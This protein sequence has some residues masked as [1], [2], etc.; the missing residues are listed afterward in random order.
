MS[1]KSSDTSL[2]GQQLNRSAEIWNL[3]KRLTGVADFE[4]CL[5]GFCL[6]LGDGSR[7]WIG[8]FDRFMER[9]MELATTMQLHPGTPEDASLIILLAKNDGT[10][11]VAY[12]P[13]ETHTWNRIVHKYWH[14]WYRP[15]LPD[16]LWQSILSDEK[17]AII[18]PFLLFASAFIYRGSI[19]RGGLPFHA[20]LVE[21][22]GQGVILAAPGGTGKTTCYQR[23]L[24]PWQAHCDDEVL[25]ALAPDGRYLAHPFPTWSNFFFQRQEKSWKVEAA[26]PLAGIFFLEQSPNDYS[27]PSGHAEAVAAATASAQKVMS[28]LFTWGDPEEARMIRRTIFAN[29]CGLVKKVPTF[30]LKVS[31]NGRFWEQIEAALGWR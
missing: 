3:L 16:M 18:H 28:Q 17:K 20:A 15:D 5:R 22:K 25:V 30:H 27:L 7:W 29:A 24:S 12:P 11:R 23:I 9:A 13:K 31:L 14:V 10:G 26:L 6:H 2:K 8:A 1:V 4:T 19:H 21:R